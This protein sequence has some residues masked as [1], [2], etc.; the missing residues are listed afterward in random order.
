MLVKSHKNIG[1]KHKWIKFDLE[2][3]SI[4]LRVY[5][6]DEYN[7]W[8]KTSWKFK[9]EDIIYYERDHEEIFTQ[10]CVNYLIEYLKKHLD[11]KIKREKTIGFF[12]PD[13]KFVFKPQERILDPILK[14]RSGFNVDI[15]M[16]LHVYFWHK[17]ATDNYFSMTFERKDI[18]RLYDYLIDVR[19]I[20]RREMQK[21]KYT[22]FDKKC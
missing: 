3:M 2:G 16:E 17:G 6:Y 11:N 9:F 22:N 5:G 14:D 21:S 19:K 10:D 15:S 7:E 20:G 13:F 18:E 12:E 8:V 1:M 4:K